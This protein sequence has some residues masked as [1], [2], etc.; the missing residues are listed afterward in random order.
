[1]AYDRAFASPHDAALRAAIAAAAGALHFDNRPGS[2]QRQCTLGLFVAALSDRLALAFPQSADALNAVVFSPSTHG[3][4][5]EKPL[6]QPEQH[7]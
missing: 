3:N 7:A 1:M 6:R 4:P 2:L 5:T